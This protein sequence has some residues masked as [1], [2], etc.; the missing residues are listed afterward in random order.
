MAV[1]GLVNGPGAE[2]HDED[3]V[4]HALG[5]AAEIADEYGQ[6]AAACAEEQ[7]AVEGNGAGGVVGG[8]EDGAQH[9]TA[10][11]DVVEHPVHTA[12]ALIAE[13][14]AEQSH[15]AHE[16]HGDAPGDD[17]AQNQIHAADDQSQSA[18]LAD[19]A[20]DLADEQVNEAV[21]LGHCAGIV[22]ERKGRCHGSGVNG[23]PE[24]SGDQIFAAHNGRIGGQQEGAACQGGVQEVLADAAVELLYHHDGE[25]GA[26]DGQP[27]GRRGRQNQSQQNTGDAGGQVADGAVLF[28][29]LAVAPL[30]EHG[31]GHGN[32]DDQQRIYAE[33]PYRHGNGGEQSD[34]HV[35]HDAAGVGIGSDLRLVRYVKNNSFFLLVAHCFASFAAAAAASASAFAF[36]FICL[37]W[38]ISFAVLNA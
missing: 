20:G 1:E 32:R 27:P 34:Y 13:D 22:Q 10:G 6:H 35:Q 24:C 31:G 26:D 12:V 18:D 30:E 19:A 9:Q 7:L 33:L 8:H 14:Q 3:G 29:E 17:L 25:E 15:S 38:N 5:E 36:S 28:Q 11:E 21:I 23:A 4:G 16:G 2:V 37:A